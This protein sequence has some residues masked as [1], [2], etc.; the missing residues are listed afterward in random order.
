MTFLVVDVSGVVAAVV[1]CSNVIISDFVVIV[2]VEDGLTND[3]EACFNLALL[4]ISGFEH[5]IVQA[6]FKVLLCLKT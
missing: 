6:L 4:D 1:Y 2:N 3:E 5:L